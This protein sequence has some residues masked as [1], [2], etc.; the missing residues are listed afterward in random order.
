MW[1][2][3]LGPQWL[4]VLAT[5]WDQ[6]YFRNLCA[7]LEGEYDTKTIYPPRELV[8][9]ALSYVQPGEIKALILGQDPYHGPGQ[10]HGLA[11]SVPEGVKLPP[12]LRNI[13]LERQADLGLPMPGSGNLQAWAREGVLLCNTVW[14]VEAGKPGSHRRRGWER[15]TKRILA[16]LA[17]TGQPLAVLLWGRDAWGYEEVLAGEGVRIWK[18]P[19]PSPLSAYRGFFGSRPFSKVNRFLEEQGITPLAWGGMPE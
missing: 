17:G 4:E 3:C 8:F 2:A 9:Q 6:P 16:Y 18:S 5:E 10:A 1:R 12:S 7:Y 14:T 15:L 13:F 11:F 19:H